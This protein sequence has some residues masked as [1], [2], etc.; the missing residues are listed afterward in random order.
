MIHVSHEKVFQMEEIIK[1]D[2]NIY[3]Q[4]TDPD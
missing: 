3:N 2:D 1:R 4:I